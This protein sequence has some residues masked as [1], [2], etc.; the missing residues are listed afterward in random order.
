MAVQAEEQ[1]FVSISST[2]SSKAKPGQSA[3]LPQHQRF[4]WNIAQ[5]KISHGLW[6][7]A[8]HEVLNPVSV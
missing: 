3:G 6:V 8:N 1:A 7:A 2:V 5:D 4:P